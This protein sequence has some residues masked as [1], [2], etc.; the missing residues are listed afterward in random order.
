[1]C[2]RVDADFL[3]AIRALAEAH[4]SPIACFHHDLHTAHNNWRGYLHGP[5]V[6][7]KK[8]LYV[9][10][11]VL[12]CRWIEAGRGMGL[13][14]FIRLVEATVT[15]STLRAA[16]DQ[17]LVLKRAAGEMGLR[18]SRKLTHSWQQKWHGLPR[19]R[20]RCRR[21]TNRTTQAWMYC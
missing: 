13:M 18:P 6:K 11:P 9:L 16:I 21:R 5:T 14:E 7:L 19:L 4:Y 20:A 3:A 12:A 2:E 8:Y 17:L 1:M 15:G 10:R